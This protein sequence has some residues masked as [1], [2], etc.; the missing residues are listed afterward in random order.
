MKYCINEIL[1]DVV[2]ESGLRPQFKKINL[3]T[4]SCTNG[5]NKFSSA[6]DS[7]WQPGAR[8]GCW[9]FFTPQEKEV[10]QHL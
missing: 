9:T 3:V 2:Q 7:P 6:T 4:I 5:G 10:F 1:Q 8:N